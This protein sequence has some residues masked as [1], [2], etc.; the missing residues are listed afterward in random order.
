MVKFL[1]SKTVFSGICFIS[2]KRPSVFILLKKINSLLF[3]IFPYIDGSSSSGSLFPSD[4]NN[5]FDIELFLWMSK[6]LRKLQ[7]TISHSWWR[8]MLQHNI[9]IKHPL[10]DDSLEGM[11]SWIS[12]CFEVSNF[13]FGLKQLWGSINCAL[14]S[15]MKKRRILTL[16]GNYLVL[17]DKYLISL[18]KHDIACF[19]NDFN[20]DIVPKNY[21]NSVLKNK[22]NMVR[23]MFSELYRKAEKHDKSDS[24]I[25]SMIIGLLQWRRGSKSLLKIN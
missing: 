2:I 9:T 13:F 6:W 16:E 7:V 17:Y 21:V 22:K 3:M 1:S 25:H 12:T 18:T 23:N 4:S 5:N 19:W 24:K 20:H 14:S 8:V 10:I 15:A 11:Y